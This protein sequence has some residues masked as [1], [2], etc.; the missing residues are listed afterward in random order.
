MILLP[1][2]LSAQT[3]VNYDESKVPAY[4]LTDLLT[5]TS[6]KKITT[7]ADWETIRKPEL[8]DLFSKEMYGVTPGEKINMKHRVVKTDKKALGGIATCKQVELVFSGNHQTRKALMVL[9]IPNA[10]SSK[11]PVFVGYNFNGNQSVNPDP[12]LLAS[13][14]IS[15]K[16]SRLSEALPGADQRRLPLELIINSG[17][18]AAT[19]YYY[20]IYPDDKSLVAK[21]V[22]PLFSDYEKTGENPDAWQAIGAWAWGLSRM[23]DYLQSEK[24]VDAQKLI[25]IGHSRQG[26]AALWA[27]AQDKRFAM[28]VS[29]NSGCGGAALFNR[30]FGETASVINTTFPHWFNR[31]FRQYN[32]REDAL[33][34]DQHALIA[35]MAPRPVYIASASNDLWADPKGEL[36]SGYHANPVYALYGLTGLPDSTMPANNT[37]VQAGYIGYHKREGDH[38]MLAYDWEQ[39]IKFAKKHFSGK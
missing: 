29:N 3:P 4:T 31:N 16:T 14:A 24:Q 23:A 32:N 27:G 25:V 5:S 19:M 10:V 12:Q 36:L 20:D 17:F 8:L 35:L 11:V 21:T 37:P 13:P 22:L 38:D 26:K 33:P 2:L 28:I 6:G 30:K 7:T 15:L 34:V 18:G 1:S 39:Y 9:W